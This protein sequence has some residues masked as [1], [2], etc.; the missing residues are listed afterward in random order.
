MIF[1]EQDKFYLS[2]IRD[3]MT[4]VFRID[5]SERG[6]AFGHETIDEWA[7]LILGTNDIEHIPQRGINKDDE[8][9][10][11]RCAR[12]KMYNYFSV[13]L[14][15][16]RVRDFCNVLGVTHLYD[17]GCQTINQSFLFTDRYSKMSYTGITNGSFDLIDFQY[18]DIEEGYYNIIT[19]KHTPMALCEGRI[20][21]IKGH[22]P[23][24]SLDILK[25]NIAIALHSFTM[26]STENEI[27]RTV[28]ALVHDFDR[29]LFNVNLYKPDL[30]EYWKKQN[31]GNFKFYPVARNGFVF[32][33]KFPE[34][35]QKLKSVY[36]YEDD[37]F[38][39]GINDRVQIGAGFS[40]S[41]ELFENYIE[42]NNV[43]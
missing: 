25:N 23:D 4:K 18:C 42:W 32:G 31:W 26:L 34:D 21:Y 22:Y 5:F 33:T 17:I 30:I 16:L 8:N 2:D 15:Y 13:N 43:N 6:T 29:I 27:T 40:K 19:T 37:K 20:Q 28:S 24:C 14:R 41:D 38:A 7:K 39:T 10:P 11:V 1:E 9:N 36:V 3:H 35:I 12:L